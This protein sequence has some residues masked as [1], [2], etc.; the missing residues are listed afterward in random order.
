LRDA[1]IAVNG[2]LI[3]S[4][5]E[6][7]SLG[8]FRV[9][10]YV[11]GTTIDQDSELGNRAGEGLSRLNEIQVERLNGGG[12]EWFTPI[13]GLRVKG[14]MNYV[15]HNSASGEIDVVSPTPGVPPGLVASVPFETD[16]AQVRD[17]I[18]GAEYQNGSL[19]VASEYRNT[20]VNILIPG[21]FGGPSSEIQTREQGAYALASY[22]FLPKWECALFGNWAYSSSDNFPS[23]SVADFRRT[24]GVALRFDPT[25]NW[26][27]KAEFQ[28]N[29][30]TLGLDRND[31]PEGMSE[32]WNL[33]AIKTT[34]DF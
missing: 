29:R 5:V 26:L 3:S 31:N 6:A 30:G 25:E 24:A 10:G 8:S 14:S 27:I 7:G 20:Y 34:F 23:D 1:L 15:S 18:V 16:T 19:T 33:L 13:D 32:Y 2:V 9:H 12:L 4:D 28:R 11:G 17:F 22:R 21:V